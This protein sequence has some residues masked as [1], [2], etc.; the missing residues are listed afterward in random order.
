MRRAA[1][2]N[3]AGA[4]HQSSWNLA[5][6]FKRRMTTPSSL[7][8][9]LSLTSMI[10]PKK[11]SFI[12]SSRSRRCRK[13]SGTTRPIK[14]RM[15]SKILKKVLALTMAVN[16]RTLPQLDR[17]WTLR[18][19]YPHVV[20]Q[21][22]AMSYQMRKHQKRLLRNLTCKPTSGSNLLVKYKTTLE[23]A[24]RWQGAKINYRSVYHLEP[25]NLR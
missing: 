3:A 12:W 23:R 11:T 6:N 24:L 4:N 5:R 15:S 1:C 20:T 16:H 13:I 18:A 10:S 7:K 9:K 21:I 19:N 8:R 17:I 2:N 22:I 14:R 25:A